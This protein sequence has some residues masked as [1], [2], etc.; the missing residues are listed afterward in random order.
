MEYREAQY[1]A[2]KQI[3]ADFEQPPDLV[4]TERRLRRNTYVVAVL[5]L[6]TGSVFGGIRVGLGVALGAALS[7]LNERWLRS[8]VG[9]I[10][11]SVT[12]VGEYRA[13]RWSASKFILRY[14]VVA[15]GVALGFWSG[16]F[17]ILGIGIGLASFV[18]AAMVEAAYQMYLSLKP[19]NEEHG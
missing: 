11:G 3:E 7:I 1:G 5:A 12:E 6:I 4:A 2:T 19:A 13:R 9:A 17:D 10:L 8:S 15:A 18:G 14:L 16:Y